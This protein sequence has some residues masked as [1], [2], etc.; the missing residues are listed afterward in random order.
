VTTYYLYYED[1]KMAKALASTYALL[2]DK[3]QSDNLK[4]KTF[5]LRMG[6]SVTATDY[7]ELDIGFAPKLLT[8][9]NLT[10]GSTFKWSDCITGT[11][12]VA[13]S[14]AAGTKYKITTIGTTDFTLIGAGSNAI[15]T[16]FIAT[17]VG[18]GTGYAAPVDNICLRK[19][20]SAAASA[21][22]TATPSI[23][24]RDRVA[25]LSLDA[26]TLML[27]ANDVALVTAIG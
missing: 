5:N 20:G 13:T 9:E 1:L 17:A 27:A 12:V 3:G 15:G 19:V 16:E 6:S 4:C 25:Q 24:T 23:L 7:L 8:V 21:L 10:T 26:T 11:P 22:V 2:A 14:L 18:V